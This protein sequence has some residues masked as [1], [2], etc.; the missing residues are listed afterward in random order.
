MKNQQ[1]NPVINTYEEYEPEDTRNIIAATEPDDTSELIRAVMVL[2]ETVKR[3]GWRI[4]AL[5]DAAEE[6]RTAEELAES[7]ALYQ[8]SPSA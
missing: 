3:Q 2:C 4:A 6:R 5:E 8:A 7:V 1:F